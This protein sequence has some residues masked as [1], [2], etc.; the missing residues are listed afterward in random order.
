MGLGEVAGESG[1]GHV[2]DLDLP[3]AIKPLFESGRLTGEWL[4]VVAMVAGMCRKAVD[5]ENG[6]IGQPRFLCFG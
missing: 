5:R 4:M 1:F 2:D 3:L 6:R